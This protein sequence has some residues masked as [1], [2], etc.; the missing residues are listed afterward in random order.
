MKRMPTQLLHALR[1]LRSAPGFTISSVSI[2]AVGIGISTA[3]FTAVD[4]VLFRPIQLPASERLITLC[5]VHAGDR[6]H[7]TASPPNVS[8]WQDRAGTIEAI[9]LARRR[10]VITRDGVRRSVIHAAVATP[11][12]MRSLGVN[13][14]HGRLL[15]SE[16]GPPDGT[17]RAIV[18]S[19]ELWQS[20]FGG[21]PEVI[22]ST[23]VATSEGDGASWHDAAVT[24]LGVL[25]PDVRVPRFEDVEAWIPF[26]FDP[27]AE[28]H[29]DW[30]G[31]VAL[32]RLSPGTSVAAAEAE[33]NRIQLQLAGAYPDAVRN[34]TVQAVGARD[35]IVKDARPLL[36][37]FL[38]AVGL[39]L[40]II[41]VNL[42]SLLLVRAT[43]R[44]RELSV[45]AALGAG[46]GRLLQ[47]LLLEVSVITVAGAAGGV[48]LAMWLV[49]AFVALAPA[50]VPRVDEI[51]MDGRALA[52]TI[53]VTAAV[54][55]V[56]GAAPMT[57]LR[58]MHLHD[59]LRLGPASSGDRR[60][61]RTRSVLVV[62]QI[63][64]ALMLVLSA[65]LLL[66]S[67]AR[68]AAFDPGFDMTR[69]LTF[70]VFPPL[71][72]YDSRERVGAFY[73]QLEQ[74]L[75][76][77][78]GVIGVGT[79]SSG[80]FLGGGDGRTPFL[81]AHREPVPI[82][83]A[84]TVEWYD[85]GPGFFPTLGIRVLEGRNLADADAIGSTPTALVNRTM[86]AL[87]WPDASPVGA[88]LSLPQWETQ[89]EVVGVVEDMRALDTPGSVPAI[90]VS[91]RQRPR[92]ATFVVVRT[93]VD[94]LALAPAVR[95]VIASL[96]PDIEPQ[97]LQTMEERLQA[98]LVA[99]RFNLLVVSLFGALALMLTAF[100]LYALIAYDVTLRTREF[101]IRMALGAPRVQILTSVLWRGGR[102]MG[103][104]IAIGVLGAYYFS[105]LLRGLLY[106]V[107]PADPWAMSGTVI[108]LA[109]SCVIACMAPAVRAGRVSPITV[110]RSD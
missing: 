36:L 85:A 29:R 18:L 22:G 60:S 68:Q 65:G 89:V 45:R 108:L 104:G 75:A 109:L 86:A 90:F 28:E 76:A 92:W 21:D 47:Q 37:M 54:T 30:R 6:T 52:F 11:G 55:L 73:A 14:L 81:I 70:Q 99:P 48:I 77:V 3:V 53:A 20:R 27:R 57:R 106:G 97:Y 23:F 96:D 102:L 74:E 93:A 19:Y 25:P 103:V 38:A 98:R 4:S 24:I 82:Q 7:C 62:T 83:E 8:D 34:W 105:R 64:L 32:G 44:Q 67:F 5:E 71:G 63:A 26:Q 78:P 13:P 69:L 80:P 107:G 72:R 66:R 101:G 43:Q 88:L 41:C 33:L 100:G 51:G 58:S 49:D 31:F 42:M 95:R 110:M 59:V 9:G 39:V 94:P 87:H 61:S 15:R 46:R 91:N 50:G 1:Q 79:A 2:L 35:W 40:L 56:C 12:F 10:A 16:D 84:P 17:G